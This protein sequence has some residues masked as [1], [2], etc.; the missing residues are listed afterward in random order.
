MTDEN[1]VK[2]SGIDEI[3]NDIDWSRVEMSSSSEGGL[4]SE[5][6][7][8][9]PYDG[10]DGL[11]HY[12]NQRA[13][14]GFNFGITIY[15]N[16]LTISGILISGLEYLDGLKVPFEGFGEGTWASYIHTDISSMRDIEETL[17]DRADYAQEL[18][19]LH[20]KN[21]RVFTPGK[22]GI[23]SNGSYMRLKVDSIDGWS[24]GVLEEGTTNK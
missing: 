3:E 5:D 17:R 10:R 12:F 15:A 11:L 18:N 20:L 22:L 13:Y 14:D 4:A 9:A 21:A 1:T 8:Y 6:P 23:P 7:P 2:P 16:G 24:H 19:F